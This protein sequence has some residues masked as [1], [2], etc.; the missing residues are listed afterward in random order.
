VLVSTGFFKKPTAI[1][2]L[3]GFIYVTD[4]VLGM[5]VIKTYDDKEKP[6]DAPK[7]IDTVGA[8]YGAL[9]ALFVFKTSFALASQVLGLATL[10]TTLFSMTF[11][12]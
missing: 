10:I 1:Q 2:A 11:L 12:F 3:D 7:K 9:Q 6:F 4:E 5:Y 8:E